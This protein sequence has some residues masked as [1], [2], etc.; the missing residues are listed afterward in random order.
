MNEETV[1]ESEPFASCEINVAQFI[2]QTSTDPESGLLSI[3]ES[4]FK[5]SNGVNVIENIE[6][7]K[8]K[9]KE[10]VPL[11]CL[12][13]QVYTFTNGELE[14]V[15]LSTLTDYTNCPED[16]TALSKECHSME[17]NRICNTNIHNDKNNEIIDEQRKENWY[18]SKDKINPNDFV[19][20]VTAF[21]CKVC[22]YTTQD[23][24]ELLSH[25]EDTHV[26]PV[27]EFQVR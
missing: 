22:P 19:E 27:K 8:D 5:E 1:E 25:L 18:P 3:G 11:V 15:D 2:L 6:S 9:D 10:T 17:S 21:K 7:D 20:I 14:E 13:G 23:K 16:A 26:N 24:T 4:D 12:E